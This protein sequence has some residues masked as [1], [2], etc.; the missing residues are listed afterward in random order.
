MGLRFSPERL[1]VGLGLVALGVLGTLA[2]SG[3]VDLLTVVHTW[4]PASLVV[5]GLAELYNTFAARAG[6][7]RD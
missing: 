1:V 6:G 2:R 4:W 3:T 7:R 5:W